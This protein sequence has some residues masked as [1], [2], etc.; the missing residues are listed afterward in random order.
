VHL[1]AKGLF[2][3]NGVAVAE[4]DSFL[5]ISETDRVRVVKYW[6]KGPQVRACVCVF[7]CRCT[8]VC[9]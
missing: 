9:S 3:S 2:Y 7:V 6:L 1:L 5:L 4:D 8:S